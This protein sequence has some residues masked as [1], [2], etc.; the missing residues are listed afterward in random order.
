MKKYDLFDK[1]LTGELSE[2]ETDLLV[3]LLEDEEVGKELVEYSLETKL[4]IDYGKKVKSRISA[5]LKTGKFKR[6][7]IRKSYLPALMIAAM[8]T[9]GFFGYQL[10]NEHNNARVSGSGVVKITR[11]GVVF[12]ENRQI[13]EGDFVEALEDTE[14]KF[15]DGS[16]LKLRHG[17]SIQ[18]HELVLNKIIFLSKGKIDISAMPQDIG[19]LKVITLDSSTE[20][21]GT[22]F[23]VEKLRKGTLLKVSEGKVQFSNSDSV[24]EVSSGQTAY[25]QAG[26]KIAQYDTGSGNRLW[27]ILNKQLKSDSTLHFY[28]DF[29]GGEHK[30]SLVLGN[31]NKDNRDR[32]FLH[33]GIISFP[34]T[35][36]FNAGREIT[37]FSWV[38][39]EEYSVHAP[40][41]TKGDKTWRLQIQNG[42]PHVGYGGATKKSHLDAATRY[43]MDFGKWYLIH[44]VI[45]Q[46]KVKIYLNGQKI[47]DQEIDSVSLN[48]SGLV[49]IGGNSDKPNYHFLGDIG[50]AGLFKRALKEEEIIEMYEMGKFKE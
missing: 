29:T 23:S 2:E 24:L 10:F 5:P 31:I 33:R 46:S 1:Y 40:V 34:N 13:K 35:I 26:E 47:T 17:T 32:Y 8:L 48:G 36:D 6:K 41:L 42:L 9:L 28:T 16:S 37:L 22:E 11:N 38:R 45:T 21:V 30:G 15:K 20:V 39:A 3:E 44:Q 4:F 27:P 19:V 43:R 50:E 14:I 12:S 49:M 25:A 18:V 7:R